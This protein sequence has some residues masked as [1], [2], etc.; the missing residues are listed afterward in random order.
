MSIESKHAYRFVYIKSDK[1]KNVRLEALARC[2]AKCQICQEES[3]SNDAHHKWYPENIWDTTADHL[4]ILCR[5]CHNFLHLIVPECK[6]QNEEEGTAMWDVFYNAIVSWRKSKIYLFSTTGG[7]TIPTPKSL[8]DELE[9]VRL[10]LKELQTTL[11]LKEPQ[12]SFE[13]KVDGM[14]KEIKSWSKS[15]KNS[16]QSV[17]VIVELSDYQI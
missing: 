2:G 16:A 17:N 8:R 4:V 10:E 1:W 6:T 9:R 14:L 7:I 3:I 13:Q 11:K 12:V 15:H 5:E